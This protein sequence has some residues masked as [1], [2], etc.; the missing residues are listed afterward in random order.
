MI[1]FKWVRKHSR[2]TP[3]NYYQPRLMS[4]RLPPLIEIECQSISILHST[5]AFPFYFNWNHSAVAKFKSRR[6]DARQYAFFFYIFLRIRILWVVRHYFVFAC[7]ERSFATM[8]NNVQTQSEHFIWFFDLN[9]VWPTS[10]PTLSMCLDGRSSVWDVC[11]RDGVCVANACLCVY[12]LFIVGNSSINS[13]S[14]I[15]YGRITDIT[16]HRQT[17]T[18]MSMA[19][20]D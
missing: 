20:P 8:Q 13:K 11:L 4:N 9:C 15:Q 1:S 7:V 10:A 2:W 19:C 3:K 6:P 5:R 12:I 14:S 18:T 16:W 17:A